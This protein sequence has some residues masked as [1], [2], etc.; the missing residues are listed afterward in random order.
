LSPAVAALSPFP[1]D[2]LLS[3]PSAYFAVSRL[4]LGATER[5]IGMAWL[6]GAI[7]TYAIV[8]LLIGIAILSHLMGGELPGQEEE[9]AP[10]ERGRQRN[11]PNPIDRLRQGAAAGTR[12]LGMR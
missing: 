8:F 10:A 11:N 7:V 5:H 1:K 12:V 2:N 3:E 4:F 9:A 6:I